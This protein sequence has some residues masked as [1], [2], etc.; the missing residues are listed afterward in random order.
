MQTVGGPG[1]LGQQL[2]AVVAE[3]LRSRS[4]ESGRAGGKCSSRAVTRAIASASRGSLLPPPRSRRRCRSVSEPRTSTICSPS[5]SRKQAIPRPI[6]PLLSIP[7]RRSPGANPATQ[8]RSA[9]CARGSFA[10]SRWASPRPS[11][12]T[13]Q[14]ATE[15]LCA[16]IPIVTTTNL[17]LEGHTIQ[18]GGAQALVRGHKLLKTRRAA[19]GSKAS[20]EACIRLRVP[21][22]SP[23]AAPAASAAA[24]CATAPPRARRPRRARM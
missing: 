2:P 22:A 4:G 12:S 18:A 16:S 21:S 10:N 8:A 24:S 7:K 11:S 14:T 15:R 19:Y 5:A 3:Q 13:R 9:Q 20:L 23:A 6:Q 1:P 17:P